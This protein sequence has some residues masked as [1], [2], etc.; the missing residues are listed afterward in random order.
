[1]AASRADTFT[2]RKTGK[3]LK[4]TLLGSALRDGKQ[5]LFVRTEDGQRRYLPKADWE[6]HR[7]PRKAPRKAGPKM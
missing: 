5:V 4:G 2:S 1:M 3:V 7:E 6:V